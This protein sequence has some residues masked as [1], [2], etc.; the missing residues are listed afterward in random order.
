MET[1]HHRLG[2]QTKPTVGDRMM[3]GFNYLTLNP[4]PKL[5]KMREDQQE[6]T[7]APAQLIGE[8]WL[9]VGTAIKEALEDTRARISSLR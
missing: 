8:A 3:K 5:R 9:S 7:K 2:L 1:T 6:A 4:A